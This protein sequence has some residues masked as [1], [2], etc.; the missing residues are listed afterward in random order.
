MAWPPHQVSTF[1]PTSAEWNAIVDA[2]STA[3]GAYNANGQVFSGFLQINIAPTAGTDAIVIAPAPLVASGIQIGGYLKWRAGSYDSSAHTKDFWWKAETTTNAGAGLFTLQA[4]LDG[5]GATTI[6]RA[7]ESVND[8]NSATIPHTN[9]LR[10]S[11]ALILGASGQG[12]NNDGLAQMASF[13]FIGS[14]NWTGI[15]F[16]GA[17]FAVKSAVGSDIRY[18]PTSTPGY[19]GMEILPGSGF[20]FYANPGASTAGATIT[21]TV[22]MGLSSTELALSVL[23]QCN[24]MTAPGTPAAGKFYVYMDSSDSKLKAKGPSGTVTILALP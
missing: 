19:A 14:Q 18:T 2:L 7:T 22:R 16:I 4:S 20:L 11:G 10:L 8:T 15:T 1:K 13:G 24:S 3:Q 6:L 17:N 21:P 9:M 23:L 5:G 12:G